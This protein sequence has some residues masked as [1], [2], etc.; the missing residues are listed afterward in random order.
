[1][2][3]HDGVNEALAFHHFDKRES[4][5]ANGVQEVRLDNGVAVVVMAATAAGRTDL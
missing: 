1:M 4:F 2:T 5:F 3:G